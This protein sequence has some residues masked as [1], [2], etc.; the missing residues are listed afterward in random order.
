MTRTRQEVVPVS[1][2]GMY[3]WTSDDIDAVAEAIEQILDIRLE[4]RHSLYWGDYYRWNGEP[5]GE[6]ILQDNFFDEQ[7]QELVIPEHPDH[8]VI[9]HASFLPKGWGE[10]ILSVPGAE[11]LRRDD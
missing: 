7:D 8:K 2:D 9:L 5:R 3:G 10:R 11:L 1:G 6:L 4:A